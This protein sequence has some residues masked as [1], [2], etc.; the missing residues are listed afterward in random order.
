[1]ILKLPFPPSANS[2][3]AG[4]VRRYKSKRYKSWLLHA[5]WRVIEQVGRERISGPWSIEMRAVRP[6]RRKRDIDNLIKPVVDLLVAVK[7]VD[8]DCEMQT[9]FAAWVPGEPEKPGYVKV[10]LF[11]H[12]EGKQ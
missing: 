4:N 11:Q 7:V 2:L 12:K 1:M 6:D 8:D 5:G 9:V 10:H 3:F